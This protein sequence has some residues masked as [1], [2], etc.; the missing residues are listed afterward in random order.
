MAFGKGE[1]CS[2][3]LSAGLSGALNESRPVSCL[4]HGPFELLQ[5]ATKEAEL[6]LDAAHPLWDPGQID[7]LSRKHAQEVSALKLA[8]SDPFFDRQ[9]LEMV[10][11]H[12]LREPWEQSCWHCW[13]EMLGYLADPVRLFNS[14]GWCLLFRSQIRGVPCHSLHSRVCSG[15]NLPRDPA[16]ALG[17]RRPCESPHPDSVYD[18][19]VALM[20]WWEGVLSERRLRM[21]ND[22]TAANMVRR[23]TQSLCPGPRW[24]RSNWKHLVIATG[25]RSIRISALDVW[26][27]RR[28]RG[29]RALAWREA[30]ASK[31]KMA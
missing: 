18:A 7:L 20:V 1:G 12:K 2:V 27:S 9:E 8:E 21:G 23:S 6:R 13:E 4:G 16:R 28:A 31:E 14:G 25:R 24:G 10:Q 5:I 22:W 30:L 15:L 3:A 29:M 17:H 19:G 26:K 11:S